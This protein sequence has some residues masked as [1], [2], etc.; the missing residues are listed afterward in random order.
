MRF[1]RMFYIL[2]F[3]YFMT[4][5]IPSHAM[6]RK[7]SEIQLSPDSFIISINATT[8]TSPEKANNGLLTRASEVTLRNG[9]KYF[10]IIDKKDNSEHVYDYWTIRKVPHREITI[11][12][13]KNDRGVNNPIDAEFFLQNKK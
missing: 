3:G 1:K 11:K 5:M 8:T 7:Y 12:C 6:G 13:F 2:L 9:Y 4:A 10:T